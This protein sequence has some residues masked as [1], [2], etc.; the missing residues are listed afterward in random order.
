MV[1]FGEDLRREREA[2]GVAIEA[3]TNSTKISS[4]HLY[5]LEQGQLERLPGGV[6]NRGIVRGY[7][8]VVGLDEDTWLD[9]FTSECQ[10]SGVA[11]QDDADWTQFAENVVKNRKGGNALNTLRLRWAGVALLLVLIAALG[12]YVYRVVREKVSAHGEHPASP[13][14]SAS[15]SADAVF[16]LPPHLRYL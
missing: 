6:F 11:A 7:A 10:A 16:E 12:V 8:R 4:R 9:R 5:A 1:Q 3:I 14:T 15:Y 2:R 13:Q